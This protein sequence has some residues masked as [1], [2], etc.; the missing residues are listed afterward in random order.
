METCR[1]I[2]AAYEA[3]IA[4]LTR[5]EIAARVGM[6]VSG[7]VALPSSEF[8]ALARRMPLELTAFLE[9]AADPEELAA[10]SRRF[11]ED[12]RIAVLAVVLGGDPDGLA[13]LPREERASLLQVAHAV[14][15]EAFR[16][17][18]PDQKVGLHDRM[19]WGASAAGAWRAVTGKAPE[20]RLH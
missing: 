15:P 13:E 7:L 2:D 14:G 12:V 16:E 4:D 9:Y 11:P 18:S 6:D 1:E 5:G 10:L 3:E 17:L 19:L 20:F 8:A